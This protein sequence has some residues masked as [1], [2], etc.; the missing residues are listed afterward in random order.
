MRRVV[1]AVVV[2]AL[3]GGAF[4]AWRYKKRVEER[5]QQARIVALRDNLAVIRK[6]LGNFH[7]DKG[8]YPHS[9]EELAPQYLRKIPVDPMTNSASWRLTTEESVQVSEDFT[10]ST[11]QK[12][13]SVVI[14]V[15]SSAPGYGDY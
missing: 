14:D 9:L 6:A 15:H 8:R 5:E 3:I 1:I 7:A 13:E 10:T 12:S 11:A 2:V 4:A